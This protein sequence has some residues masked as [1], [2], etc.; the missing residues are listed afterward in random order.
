MK[1]KFCGQLSKAQKAKAKVNKVHQN[2]MKAK[3]STNKFQEI[4]LIL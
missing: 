2:L 1:A 3:Y 4:L